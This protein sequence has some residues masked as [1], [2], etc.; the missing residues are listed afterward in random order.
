MFTLEIRGSDNAHLLPNLT[1]IQ[2]TDRRHQ[3]YAVIGVGASS[4]GRTWEVEIK[5]QPAPLRAAKPVVLEGRLQFLP[6]DAFGPR[7]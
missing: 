2:L 7:S 3:N 1:N 6:A 5:I 4:F